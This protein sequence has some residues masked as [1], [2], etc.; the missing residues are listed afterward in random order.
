MMAGVWGMIA[1]AVT[2]VPLVA[3]V[4][5]SIAS[6]REEARQSLGGPARGLLQ[7]M[8][9]Q[10]LD[11]HSEGPYPPSRRDLTRSRASV[12]ASRTQ[13][14]RP[15]SVSPSYRST[16]DGS[17]SS[18]SAPSRTT[19]NGGTT[20]GSTP[21][22]TTP[23][24]SAPDWTTAHGSTP[25]GS[26]PN[27]GTP[28]GSAPGGGDK[29]PALPPPAPDGRYESMALAP[30]RAPSR[31][32]SGRRTRAITQT[33]AVMTDLSPTTDSRWPTSGPS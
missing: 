16:P 31:R 6:R 28:S 11:F 12:P 23:L 27:G 22:W 19:L 3:I 26:T 33:S 25:N 10:I 14:R 21:D 15:T 8:A 4:V 20:H 24:G 17:P 9:R 18:W 2:A 29:A 7:A 30:G 5:V 1:L 13:A 32:R